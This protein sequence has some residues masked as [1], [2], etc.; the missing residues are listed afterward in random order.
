MSSVLITEELI[1]LIEHSEAERLKHS[2]ELCGGDVLEIGGGVCAFCGDGSPMT[3]CV[4]VGVGANL[5]DSEFSQILEFFEGRTEMFEFKLSLLTAPEL[6]E[7]VVREAKKLPEF[8]TLLV[9]DLTSFECPDLDFEIREI[10]LDEAPEYG[11]RAVERFF[12]GKEVPSL[13]GE[14]VGKCCVSDRFHSYE[15]LIDGEPV[16][17]CGLGLVEG[18]AWLQ[19]ASVLPEHRGWGLHKMMQ[20]YRMKI[21]KDAGY[22]L[23][24]QGAKPGSAS[25]LNAQKQ[26]FAVAFTRPCF[27][28]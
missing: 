23:V 21:A 2:A 7:W 28:L 12:A 24:V 3:N 10:P 20:A 9:S 16:A 17:G 25:Q 19:G 22:S 18:L 4:A 26:G 8:E 1:S 27:L 5:T 13:A 11:K 14:V 6:R 15:V